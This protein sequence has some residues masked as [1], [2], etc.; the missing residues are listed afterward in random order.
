MTQVVVYGLELI[1]KIG[2]LEKAHEIVDALLEGLH[3]KTT[4]EIVM[5]NLKSLE[6]RI[7]L[8]NA[9]RD[10]ELHDKFDHESKK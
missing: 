6:N 7:T 9:E 8:G 10:K 4:P 1:K 3:N 5:I 2:T